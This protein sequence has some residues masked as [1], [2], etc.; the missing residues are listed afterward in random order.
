MRIWVHE[1]KF[2]PPKFSKNFPIGQ[3]FFITICKDERILFFVILFHIKFIRFLAASDENSVEKNTFKLCLFLNLYWGT[4]SLVIKI[5]TRGSHYTKVMQYWF[6]YYW[7]SRKILYYLKFRRIK[8]PFR[9]KYYVIRNNSNYIY[10][11]TRRLY[12]S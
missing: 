2:S 9:V 7:F 8:F 5:C 1:L 3:H 10:I 4:H 11:T 12:S 6:V